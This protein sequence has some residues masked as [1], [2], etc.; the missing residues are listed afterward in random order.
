VRR[1]STRAIPR[2]RHPPESNLSG[3]ASCAFTL[4]ELLVVIAIIAILAALLV[5]ALSSARAKADAASCKSNLRQIGLGL[6][7][8][9][10][11]YALYPVYNPSSGQLWF[12]T[13]EPYT[14]SRH[15]LRLSTNSFQVSTI[16]LCPGFRR[17]TGIIPGSSAYGYNVN[18]AAVPN[19]KGWGLGLG[20]ER[21]VP[22]NVPG[23]PPSGVRANRE[24]EIRRPTDMIGLG[25]TVLMDFGGIVA[26]DMLDDCLRIDTQLPS[27]EGWGGMEQRQR[28]RHDA[29]FNVW[30]CDGH[31]EYLRLRTLLSGRPENLSRWNNDNSPHGDLVHLTN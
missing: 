28:G 31:I 26:S 10:Q 29:R 1:V 18:G 11:D 30:F 6:Q 13:L 19:K 22:D 25:D 3:G 4:I 9:L 5:P 23:W 2:E 8:Y 16:Y 24:A 15:T 27:F 12:D 14:G 7:L 17:V 21:L 20:G